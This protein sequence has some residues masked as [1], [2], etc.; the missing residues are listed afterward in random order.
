MKLPFKQQQQKEDLMVVGMQEEIQV[1][2]MELL[3]AKRKVS[4]TSD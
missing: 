4:V 1:V 3:D 2:A